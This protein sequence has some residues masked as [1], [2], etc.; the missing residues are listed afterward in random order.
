MS[1]EI[2]SNDD[3]VEGVPGALVE[4]IRDRAARLDHV[5]RTNGVSPAPHSV[6][7]TRLN[8][9]IRRVLTV[10]EMAELDLDV[11]DALIEGAEAAGGEAA[12]ARLL[13]GV[14]NIDPGALKAEP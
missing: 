9:L 12:R 3:V 10:T 5:M 4:K 6:I 13:E 2:P 11:L 8:M 7:E 14:P 1:D